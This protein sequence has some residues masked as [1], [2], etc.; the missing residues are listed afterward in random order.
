MSRN[1]RMVIVLQTKDKEKCNIC[2][3][4]ARVCNILKERCYKGG[5][6]FLFIFVPL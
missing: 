1:F 2:A 5:K 4:R 3:H 6:R